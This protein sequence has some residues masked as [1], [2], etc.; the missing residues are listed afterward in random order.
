MGRGRREKGGE[1]AR[2]ENERENERGV[3]CFHA[4]LFFG[5]DSRM[6]ASFPALC[7]CTTNAAKISVVVNTTTETTAVRGM[8][9]Q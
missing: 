3:N 6:F 4:D 2:R 8:Q 9:Q 1:G 5:E 7:T